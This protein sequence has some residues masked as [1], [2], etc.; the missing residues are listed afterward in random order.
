MTALKNT[1]EL[2]DIEEAVNDF[3]EEVRLQSLNMIKTL[4]VFTY[5]KGR[6]K[7]F[8]EQNGAGIYSINIDCVPMY[9]TFDIE[10]I[11]EKYN[12][13]IEIHRNMIHTSIN[14]NY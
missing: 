1:I 12:E 8:L 10:W 7:L 9:H 14:Q 11:L 13:Q 4:H 3:K 2:N 6:S 5:N